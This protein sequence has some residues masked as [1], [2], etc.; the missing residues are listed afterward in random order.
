MPSTLTYPGVYVEEI[1][2]GVRTIVGV[3]TSDTAFVD[4]FRRGPIN[5][6][7]RITSFP[8][9]E[10]VFGGLDTRSEASYGIQQYYLNGGSIA[11][12]VRVAGDSAEPA[13]LVLQGG[14]PP[15]DALTV[16]SSSPG[17][18]DDNLQVGISHVPDSDL[19]NLVV[20]EVVTVNGR[21]QVT[22]S[23]IHRNLSM[24]PLS[25]RYV[26]SV[27]NS[28]SS[29]LRVTGVVPGPRPDAAPTD[30]TD[31]NLI[32]NPSSTAY[33][34]FRTNGTLG[35]DGSTPDAAT[36][37][38]GMLALDRIAPFIF[39][40][41]CIPADHAPGRAYQRARPHQPPRPQAK[42]RSFL[43]RR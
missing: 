1:P 22:N 9:F 34:A 25:G 5:E 4:F 28:D 33:S 30:V 24:S 35:N 23:E 27:I 12:V 31:P 43:W 41:L 38:A 37:I 18:W 40:I 11:W 3:S 2:S 32:S 21:P 39:N 36:L 14:S 29:L 6:A 19:F 17:S 42:S 8:D 20:R 7:V 10:R 15:G 13:Q 16:V 26:Q